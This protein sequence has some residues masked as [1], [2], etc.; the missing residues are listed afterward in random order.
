MQDPNEEKLK[1]PV[2]ERERFGGTDRATR[3][4]RDIDPE[5]RAPIDSTEMSKGPE[6]LSDQ[7][8]SRVNWRV[9][10]VASLI[11]LAFS[12]W[13]IMMPDSAQSTMKTAVD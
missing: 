1:R 12:V 4:S 7:R 8:G 10:I 6:E 5:K 3:I 13:A 2:V 9:F 11:I